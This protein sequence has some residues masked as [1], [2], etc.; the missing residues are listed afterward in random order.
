[1]I[2]RQ[3]IASLFL[4]SVLCGSIQAQELFPISGGT[5][6][7]PDPKSKKKIRLIAENANLRLT[8]GE[9]RDSK[10]RSALFVI[11]LKVE[12]LSDKPLTV[13]PSKFSTV[14]DT[15][16]GYVGLAPTDAIKRAL[17]K[18]AGTR[19]VIGIIMAGPLAGPAMQHAAERKVTEM[20]NRES[21]Q[22]GEIP[23]HSFK[24]GGVF[25]EAPKQKHFTLKINLG[26]LWPEPFIFSTEKPKK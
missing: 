23:A 17:D 21:L 26:E 1:M 5:K 4:L 7:E 20:V 25:F 10:V 19:T 3:L 8:V 12:N 11:Y 2:V 14:D 6:T 24:D 13:D 18:S 15:G 9:Y 16:R 22:P